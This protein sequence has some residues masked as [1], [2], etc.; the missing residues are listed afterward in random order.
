MKIGVFLPLIE[1][2]GELG[3]ARWG[4]IREM[5]TLAEGIGFDSLW[6]PDHLLFRHPGQGTVGMWEGMSVLAALAAVTERVEFGPL[7][8]CTGF[9]NP[10]LLA[11]MADTIDEIGGGRFVLGIG[12]GWH[13]PEY[14]AFGY[15]FDHRVGRFEEAIT[16]I[17]GLLRTGRIDFA[18]TYYQARDCELRP[19]GPRPEGPPI[20]V[21]SMGER[22]LRLAA[23]YA[24]S[25]NTNWRNTPEEAA[26]LLPRID[27]ACAAE[28][29]DPATLE[30]TVGIQIDLAGE[31][32][33]R[34]SDDGAPPLRGTPEELAAALR[35]YAALGFTHAQLL[36]E[37]NTPAALEQLAP[38]L[39]LF[40]RG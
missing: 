24:D 30:R 15:P 34:G 4:E 6:V 32:G 29:R 11:K 2:P 31:S 8:L 35:A 22:M 3:Q 21:G 19:R 20:L 26:A 25:V 39:E 27:A 36:P 40:D 18:G 16:I 12:A 7:V 23:R 13:R 33:R 38:V 17:H 1:R 14:D 28:G 9:R 10:A 37:P 5:A